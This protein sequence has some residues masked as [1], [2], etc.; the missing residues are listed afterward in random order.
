MSDLDETLAAEAE[1]AEQHK[2]AE[3]GPETKISRPNRTRSNV[4]S[5]QLNDDEMRR[6]AAVAPEAG[7]E[8]S[9]MARTVIARYLEGSS[10]VVVSAPA[11][12]ALAGLAE[13]AQILGVRRQRAWQL[14]QGAGFPEPVARLAATS[15]WLV[16]DVETW[17]ANWTR[18][19]GRP[20]ARP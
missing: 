5:V 18:R 11:V 3:P 13:V 1:Y 14:V 4:F 19:P 9:T 7:I 2:D 15:V 20:S 17:A 16:A 8:P 10:T 6:L 12:P